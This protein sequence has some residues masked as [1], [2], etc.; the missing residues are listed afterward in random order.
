M[1]QSVVGFVSNLTLKIY[2]YVSQKSISNT[3]I[4]LNKS[5]FGLYYK[6][7]YR[8]YSKL[9]SHFHPSLIFAGRSRSQPLE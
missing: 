6:T 9:V 2:R 5:N 4:I 1:S 7:F 3:K 8:P